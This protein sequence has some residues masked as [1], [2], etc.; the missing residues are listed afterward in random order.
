MAPVGLAA[1]LPPSVP[2]LVLVTLNRQLAGF[3]RGRAEGRMERQALAGRTDGRP[4]L[5][6]YQERASEQHM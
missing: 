3:V 1:L 2:L 5:K 4:I 6:K